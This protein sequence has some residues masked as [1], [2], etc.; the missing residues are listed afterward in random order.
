MIPGL[1]RLMAVGFVVLTVFYLL[2]WLYA[3]SVERERL[4]KLYDAGEAGD[5]TAGDR[6]AFITAGM[7]RYHGSLRRRLLWGVYIVPMS[8]IVLLVYI[9]NFQ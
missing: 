1:L 9:L 6:D 2:I 4:E 7:E 5:G 8:V 3:R